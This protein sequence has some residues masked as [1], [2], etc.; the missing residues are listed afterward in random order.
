MAWL[1]GRRRAHSVHAFAVPQKSSRIVDASLPR[2]TR[3]VLSMK[4]HSLTTSCTAS[5]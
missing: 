1:P 4:S 3:Q 2:S 5:S